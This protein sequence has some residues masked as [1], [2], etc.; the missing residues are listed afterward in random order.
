MA[1]DWPLVSASVLACPVI[2]NYSVSESNIWQKLKGRFG[3]ILLKNSVL[4]RVIL[5]LG[6]RCE[7]CTP[8]NTGF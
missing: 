3:S 8:V 1:S 4:K 7:V 6:F 2:T 5:Q